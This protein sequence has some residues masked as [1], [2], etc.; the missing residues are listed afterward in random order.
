MLI[1]KRDPSKFEFALAYDSS[2]LVAEN[3]GEGT[4]EMK[5]EIKD[6]AYSQQNTH[7]GIL[8]TAGVLISMAD[9]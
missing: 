5:N 9:T 4:L 2:T 1:S 8:A 3:D 6:S 7:L